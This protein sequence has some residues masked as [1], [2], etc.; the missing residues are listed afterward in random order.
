VAAKVQELI[1]VLIIDDVDEMRGLL[2]ELVS[3]MPGFA[4]SG[5]ARNTSEARL[6]LSRHKPDIVLLDEVL[7][8]ESSYDL[9]PEFLDAG[10]PVV[11]MTS[12]EKPTHSIPQGVQGRVTKPGWSST[13]RDAKGLRAA[14]LAALAR[15]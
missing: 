4:V 3:R 6:A 8:G 9:I 10:V 12:V 7:P 2:A 11:L 13:L 5:T 1:Q 15:V 14:L